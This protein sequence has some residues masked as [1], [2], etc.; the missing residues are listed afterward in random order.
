MTSRSVK[1]SKGGKTTTPKNTGGKPVT[2]P[3]KGGKAGKGGK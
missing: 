2:K 3:P 1:A